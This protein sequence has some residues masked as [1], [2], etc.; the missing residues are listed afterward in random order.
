MCVMSDK[1]SAVINRCVPVANAAQVR[2]FANGTV[3]FAVRNS[4]GLD[5]TSP[6]DLP[7]NVR[8][9]TAHESH[10]AVSFS[11]RGPCPKLLRL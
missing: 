10:V 9:R 3:R 2:T 4:V 7:V 11:E 8:R 6:A 1:V 5:P